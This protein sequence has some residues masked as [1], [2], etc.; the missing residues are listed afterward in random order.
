[1]T[2]NPPRRPEVAAVVK[3]ILLTYKADGRPWERMS[4]WID[5]IGWPRF[6]ELTELPFTKYHIEDWR[7]GRESFNASSHVHF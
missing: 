2:D 5:R 3:T 4:E 1:M 6:F 7:D